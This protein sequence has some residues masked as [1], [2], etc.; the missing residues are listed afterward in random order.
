M[1]TKIQRDQDTRERRYRGTIIQ[2]KPEY[3]GPRIQG[4]QDTVETG[5]S[6]NKDTEG[7]GYKGTRIQGNQDTGGNRI[8]GL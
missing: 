5:Y 7:P 2:R 1:K 6:G 3:R 4:N 8:L